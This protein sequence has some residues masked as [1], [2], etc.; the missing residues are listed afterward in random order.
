MGNGGKTSSARRFSFRVVLPVAVAVAITVVT[1]AGFAWWSTAKRDESAL[2]RETRLVEKAIA[3]EVE[4]LTG[5]QDNYSNWDDLVVALDEEDMDWIDASLASPLYSEEGFD[6]VYVLDPDVGVV[7]AMHSGGATT[8]DYFEADRGVVGPMIA[9]L[10]AINAAGALAAYDSGNT[11]R[12][13]NVADIALID[14]RPAYVGVSAIMSASGEGPLKQVPGEESFLVCIRFLDAAMAAELADQYAI[15][16]PFFSPVPSTQPGVVNHALRDATG[17][18]IGWFAWKPDR[19]G[20]LILAETLPAVAGGLA[21]AAIVLMLLL[22]G[23]Y[24]MTVALEEGKARAEHQADHDALTGLAN[25]A[26]FD[27]RLEEISAM[28]EPVALLA[29]DL[30]RFKQV[31]DTLG[32]E[33]GDELLREV[34]RRLAPLIGEDDTVA[35]LGGDEFA[36]IKRGIGSEEDVA[37]LSTR[38]IAELCAPFVVGGQIARIGVSIGAVVSPANGLARDL[39]AKADIALYEAKAAGRNTFR[40]FDEA[41]HRAA[42]FRDAVGEKMQAANLPVARD[43]VA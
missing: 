18:T 28:R 12:V 13:P 20:A 6:R 4:T 33:A 9:K 8:A 15:D 41:M 14:G 32:H 1:I 2:R 40:I 38:I 36:I 26:R 29:L 43:R 25:R 7:Y 37:G 23:L 31:N 39:V 30:D 42:R 22:R 35:R 5:Q 24:R 16:A 10:T 17:R 21:I 11:D 34:G 27:R 3:L 19:P